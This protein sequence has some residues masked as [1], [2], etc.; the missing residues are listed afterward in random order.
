MT[1][2]KTDYARDCKVNPGLY[3]E[4]SVNVIV[5]NDNSKQTTTSVALGPDGNCQGSMKGFSIKTGK[6]LYRL[7]ITPVPW[8]K[9]NCLI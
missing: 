2:L 8:P 4:T 1:G 3:V 9:E 6:I 7:I 5:T